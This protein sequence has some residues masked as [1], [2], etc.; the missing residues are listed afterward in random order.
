MLEGAE[1]VEHRGHVDAV[2][3][4]EIANIQ[5]LESVEADILRIVA[6]KHIT[7]IQCRFGIEGPEVVDSFEAHQIREHLA[8]I[9][10]RCESLSCGS[11]G[12]GT[13]S[14]LV[15]CICGNGG[16]E[17]AYR[18]T[19]SRRVADRED[20][21]L[22]AEIVIFRKRSG[23]CETLD[24]SI[25]FRTGQQDRLAVNGGRSAEV[26]EC[27]STFVDLRTLRGNTGTGLQLQ[28]LAASVH[29]DR[30]HAEIGI[31]VGGNH[32]IEG[33]GIRSDSHAVAAVEGQAGGAADYSRVICHGK[34]SAETLVRLEFQALEL[35]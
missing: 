28:G 9:L 32:H 27:Q 13:R 16:L 24:G 14:G 19:F 3:S 23:N 15:C 35:S 33:N 4:I 26:V 8:C 20:D 34:L 31:S 18:H 12:N 29:Q 2:R 11:D 25:E 17:S 7:H 22:D 1:A 5:T 6:S 30:R 21:S 10:T